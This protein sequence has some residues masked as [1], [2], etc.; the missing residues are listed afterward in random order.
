[1]KVRIKEVPEG[2]YRSYLTV[3]KEYEVKKATIKIV[4]DDGDHLEIDLTDCDHLDGGLWE[5][6]PDEVTT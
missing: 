1:M 4:D 6:I 3:G 2:W 5:I